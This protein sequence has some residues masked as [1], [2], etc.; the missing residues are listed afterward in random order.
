MGVK[1]EIGKNIATEQA[2]PS[3]KSLKQNVSNNK[4]AVK[5]NNSE[6]TNM[7]E[8]FKKAQQKKNKHSQE[9]LELN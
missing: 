5:Q 2:A 4:P 1:K 9:R 7:G 8:A 6:N 3:A